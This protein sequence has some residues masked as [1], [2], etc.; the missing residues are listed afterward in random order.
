LSRKSD[1]N[2]TLPSGSLVGAGTCLVGDVVFSGALRVDGAI[3]GDVRARDGHGG[4]LVVG[5]HGRIDG[6]VEA[7]HVVVVGAVCGRIVARGVLELLAKA[8]VNCD[9]EY[10]TAQIHSGAVVHG[11]LRRRMQLG[12]A[13]EAAGESSAL[14]LAAASA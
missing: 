12:P 14:D 11:Q 3:K 9:V 4:T 5:E 2:D 8:R 10:V 6:N 1:R 7:G 13:G